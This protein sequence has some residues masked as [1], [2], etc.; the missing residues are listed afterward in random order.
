L[1]KIFEMVTKRFTLA[2]FYCQNTPGSSEQERQALEREY[3]ESLR[4]FPLPC[5][6]RMDPLH[7]EGLE[8]MPM[9]CSR[10]LPGRACRYFEETG[11]K[12]G[13]RTRSYCG[14]RP[15]TEG[16]GV[17]IRTPED[18]SPSALV[19]IPGAGRGL[20]LTAGNPGKKERNVRELRDDH[21]RTKP[22]EE[23]R[24]MINLQ[25]YPVLGCNSCVAECAAG[26]RRRLCSP[27]PFM[28]AWMERK[29]ALIQ[30]KA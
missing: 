7:L 16:A 25:A 8:R 6:G 30:E 12:E 18:T 21:S 22:V 5:G 23:I 10:D 3:G 1:R 17:L 4:L 11:G 9:P 27:R 29:D 14:N 13:G 28:A 20:D 15:R 19:K 24:G 26:K 2:L